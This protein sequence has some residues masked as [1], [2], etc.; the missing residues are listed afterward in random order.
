M[1]RG[2]EE[3]LGQGI[4]SNIKIYY[5]NIPAAQQTNGVRIYGDQKIQQFSSGGKNRLRRTGKMQR[6]EL[7]RV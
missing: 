4:Q 5:M 7:G 2:T 6:K 1:H 3:F